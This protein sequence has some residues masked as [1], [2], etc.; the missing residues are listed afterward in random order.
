EPALVG[1]SL[2]IAPELSRAIALVDAYGDILQDRS[3]A[4]GGAAAA[5]VR[6][7]VEARG[8]AVI[9]GSPDEQREQLGRLLNRRRS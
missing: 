5:E 4:V 8:G 3:W 6:S 9:S 7:L 2:T 1:L